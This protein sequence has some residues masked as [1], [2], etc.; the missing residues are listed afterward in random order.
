MRFLDK[1]SP[2]NLTTGL[3][4]NAEPQARGDPMPGKRNPAIQPDQFATFGQLLRFLRQRAGLTQRELS[5]ALGYS[6]SQISRLEKN[7]RAPDRATL[8]ARFVPALR[9][10]HEPA[11]AA[12]CWSWRRRP[13]TPGL[14][15]PMTCHPSPTRLCRRTTCPRSSP[16]SSAGSASWLSSTRS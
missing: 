7:Q 15:P 8:A 12:R 1:N 2:K 4:W 6:D 5:I 13:L 10:E 14:T 11:W 3:Y 9:L 16:V